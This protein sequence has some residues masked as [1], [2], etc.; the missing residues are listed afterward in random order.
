MANTIATPLWITRES[1]R[2]L[3]QK[4]NFIG[5]INRQYDNS[6]VVS[7]AKVG[8][9]LQVRLPNKYTIRSGATMS[10]QNTVERYVT[11]PIGT[12]KGVDMNFSSQ[13]LTMQLDDFSDR[14]IKPAI[15][16]LAANVEA[17]ALNMLNSVYNYVGSSSTTVGFN[18]FA[19]LQRILADSLAPDEA[20]TL[21]LGTQ[22]VRDFM[23]D[24]KGLF[25]AGKAL[26]EQYLDGM[27]DHA[28]GFDVFRNSLVVPHTVGTYAGTPV[29]KTG[30]NQGNA[31]T[32]NAYVSTSV[33]STTGWSSGA[34]TLNVGDIITISSVF[35]VHDETKA[36]LGYLKQ[37]V[38]TSTIS[39]TV[40]EIDAVIS[41][42]IIYGGAYQNVSAAAVAAATIT[43]MA[44]T[45]SVLAQSVGYHRDAFIFASADLIQPGTINANEWCERQVMDGISMR[46]GRRWDVVND[47]FP[48]RCDV[49]YGYT[50]ALIETACRMISSVS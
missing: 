9:N 26:E 34:S 33:L 13:E 42:G 8:Q 19:A 48:T 14:I 46:I 1:L 11:L 39:D 49:F 29:V 36:N 16:R 28:L 18:S 7:G 15:T 5:R 23:T 41:P 27:V 35:A 44:A 21:T 20:L 4:A 32:G 30:A 47:F 25:H 3:H 22:Q 43:V 17:D 40:G 6:F 2:I 24:T 31:G 10:T 45:G 38:V 12:Q 37:F 50:T